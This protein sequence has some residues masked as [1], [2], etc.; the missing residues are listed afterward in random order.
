MSEKTVMEKKCQLY[1][2]IDHMA[3]QLTGMAGDLSRIP[4]W[5]AAAAVVF[6]VFV[7]MAAGF[8]PALRAMKLSPLA[9]IRNE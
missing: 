4:P 5:L 7:G 1:E 6:A 2:A 9:A 8:M 3:E